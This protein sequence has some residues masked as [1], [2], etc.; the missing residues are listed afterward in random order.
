MSQPHDVAVVIGSLRK[1]SYNR[2]I[3]QA[4]IEL[5]PARFKPEFVEI[6]QLPLC[7]QD[8]DEANPVEY[9]PFRER[10]ARAAVVSAS[11]AAIGG[12]GA[13]HHLRQSLTYLDMPV[14]QR[15]EACIGKVQDLL[16][17]VSG[18]LNNDATRDFLKKFVDRFA[19]WIERI[20]PC[21][22]Q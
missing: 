11:I 16:D 3:A 18:R 22:A 19:A 12:F 17:P 1:A 9:A 13:N 5:A 15:P 6:A 21:G 10:I 7:N 14:L 8:Y 20:V 2:K 4:P